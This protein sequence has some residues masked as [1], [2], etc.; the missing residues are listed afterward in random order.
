MKGI[1][2]SKHHP[3]F[4]KSENNENNCTNFRYACMPYMMTPYRVADTA[5][6]QRFNTAHCRARVLI[7]MTFGRWKR[8]FSILHSEVSN[9][10][11]EKI[12]F[13]VFF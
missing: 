4:K 12:E 1:F 8:R 10:L 2:R 6:K 7:E 13:D 9:L 5:A 3:Q 11:H